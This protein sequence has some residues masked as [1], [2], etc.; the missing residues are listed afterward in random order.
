MVAVR[1]SQAEADDL[2]ARRGLLSRSEWLRW[3]LVK[4]RRESKAGK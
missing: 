4:A 1:L 2:D 3:M